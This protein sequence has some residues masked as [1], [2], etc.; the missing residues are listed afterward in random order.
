MYILFYYTQWI[1]IVEIMEIWIC[2]TWPNIDMGEI[3]SIEK[4]SYTHTNTHLNVCITEFWNI[5]NLY[6]N[7]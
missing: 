2:S 3:S 7:L 6:L 5:T 4:Y 1:F